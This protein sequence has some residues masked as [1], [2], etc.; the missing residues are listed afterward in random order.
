MSDGAKELADELERDYPAV[1]VTSVVFSRDFAGVG[2][3]V[4][5]QDLVLAIIA[6]LRAAPA[7]SNGDE[8][9]TPE[10]RYNEFTTILDSDFESLL[11]DRREL[12][13]LRSQL[14]T[15]EA[16][17]MQFCKKNDE[18]LEKAIKALEE[19]LKENDRNGSSLP[20]PLLDAARAALK[21]IT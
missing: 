11:A 17:Y 3:C 18:K 5:P 20:I 8:G 19:I 9:I 1:D 15:A 6:A 7:Q 4:I 21:E 16:N 14:A 2:C 13:N 12:T 10:K